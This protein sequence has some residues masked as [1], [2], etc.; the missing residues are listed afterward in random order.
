M[1]KSQIPALVLFALCLLIV[2]LRA[3]EIE[4]EYGTE[5]MLYMS[6][7]IL[8]LACIAQLSLRLFNA[9]RLRRRY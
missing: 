1:P 4:I 8:I 7:F 9:H 5:A 6:A 3:M 2:S